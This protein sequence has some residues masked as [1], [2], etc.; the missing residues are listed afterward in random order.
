[1][2]L[3]SESYINFYLIININE[4]FIFKKINK[5][6]NPKSVNNVTLRSIY[7]NYTYKNKYIKR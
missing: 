4:L 1:M 5:L 2:E 3:L 7:F 6:K